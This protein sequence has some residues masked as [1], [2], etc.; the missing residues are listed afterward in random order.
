MHE[1]MA[2]RV[3]WIRN[4]QVVFAFY[5][6][7]SEDIIR[8]LPSKVEKRWFRM[9]QLF[10]LSETKNTTPAFLYIIKLNTID[11]I[12]RG[13]CYEHYIICSIC[14]EI[15]SEVLFAHE[16]AHMF[17]KSRWGAHSPFVNEGLA[18]Y[19][20]AKTNEDMNFMNHAEKY[21]VPKKLSMDLRKLEKLICCSD[22]SKLLEHLKNGEFTY[23]MAGS[24]FFFIESQVGISRLD[25]MLGLPGSKNECRFYEAANKWLAQWL[26]WLRDL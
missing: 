15:A 7:I 11:R 17:A 6:G 20:A 4:D 10:D 3:L 19:I 21:I 8:C 14:N 5:E 13:S 22:H 12:F 23:Q 9:N 2:S 25:Y 1:L 26:Y 24:L 16:E 18:E